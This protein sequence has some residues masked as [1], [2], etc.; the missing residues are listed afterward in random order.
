MK[1]RP[2]DRVAYATKRIA[3]VGWITLRG[4][5]GPVTSVQNTL[6]T[7]YRARAKEAREEAAGTTN[8]EKRKLLLQNAELW[9]RMA[10]YEEKNNPRR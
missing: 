8:N 10:A 5:S 7:Q 4:V 2:T 6:P 1:R 3:L 9:E